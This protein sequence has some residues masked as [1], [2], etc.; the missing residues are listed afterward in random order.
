MS[1]KQTQDAATVP[2]PQAHTTLMNAVFRGGSDGLRSIQR[3]QQEFGDIVHIQLGPKSVY[4][5]FHPDDAQ[6]VLQQNNRNYIKGELIE[7]LRAAG[8]EG[9]FTSE[10]S[11]WFRQRR[12]MQ[13]FFHRRVI[14]GFAEIMTTEINR[15]LERWPTLSEISLNKEMMKLTLSVVARALFTTTM[16]DEALETVHQTLGPILVENAKR[17]RRPFS[18]M[19]KLPL[20]ANRIYTRNREKLNA[21]VHDIIE[22][23]RNDP[24]EYEDLLQMLID[25]ADEDTGEQ[26]TDKQIRD[27]VITLFVAGHETTA[28]AL[29]WA[30]KLLSESPVVR[31]KLQVEVNEVLGNRVPTAEDYANLPF[32]LAVFEETL[33]LYPP[34]TMIPR[35]MLEAD[36]LC[37]YELPAGSNV[38]VS[39]FTLHRHPAFW[40]N[41]EGFDPIRFLPEN[42]KERHRFAYLPFSAGPRFCIGDS[43]AK[44]EAVLA[45]AMIS[46]RFEL[47]L[48]GGQSIG[49]A[50]QGTLRPNP[51]VQM[52][53]VARS[54][55]R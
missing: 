2:G 14:A 43:F 55:Q 16:S 30:F 5:L 27:E 7:N 25:A 11:Y 36:T 46:Q 40:D 29:T 50:N 23:R 35:Q 21:L 26:M 49:M 51:D 18:F 6:H 53:L 41:P 52:K 20:P 4:M 1:Q 33:R 44:M 13:P 15:L 38:V 54:D 32:T 42:N 31:R 45:L 17:S 9:L 47:D 22:A 39:T 19:E 10:G 48:V 37:G 3:L 28:T 8:G 12:M 24:G 34:V